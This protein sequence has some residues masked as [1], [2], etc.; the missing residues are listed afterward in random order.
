MAYACRG[1]IGGDLHLPIRKRAAAA[2]AGVEAPHSS[3]SLSEGRYEITGGDWQWRIVKAL[4]ERE[5]G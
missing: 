5:T 2:L 4:I 3:L 1:E